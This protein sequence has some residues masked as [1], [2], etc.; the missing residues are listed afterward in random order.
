MKRDILLIESDDQQ[1]VS[2]VRALLKG[3]Y[4]VTVCSSL[5]EA[6][7]VLR[8]VDCPEAAPDT[9]LF[10]SGLARRTAAR[11]ER[12]LVERF[13]GIKVI[14]LPRRYEP[15][16]FVAMLGGGASVRST[17]ASDAQAAARTLSVL[18]IEANRIQ[19]TAI[20]DDLRLKGDDV[21]GC[22]SVGEAA[23]VFDHL[24][25]QGLPVDAVVSATDAL[26]AEG[27]R[28]CASATSRMPDLRWIFLKEPAPVGEPVAL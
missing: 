10:G 3:A 13:C 22:S 25:A 20:E 15:E 9:V 6:D 11:F 24:V 5:E 12:A 4:R 18:L 8:Y 17:S 19:R 28:F 27:L 2:L 26:D 14:R 21:V 23:A 16:S 7:E 1:R